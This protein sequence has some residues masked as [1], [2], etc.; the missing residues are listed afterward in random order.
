MHHWCSQASLGQT[1]TSP[2]FTDKVLGQAIFEVLNEYWFITSGKPVANV[3][4]QRIWGQLAYM[5]INI[6]WAFQEVFSQYNSV[7]CWAIHY[8]VTFI[9]SKSHKALV[10]IHSNLWLCLKHH[11]RDICVVLSGSAVTRGVVSLP[12]YP[13]NTAVG[14][15]DIFCS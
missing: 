12:M 1:H 8:P 11:F 2:N 15:A 7:L 6:A 13:Q 14:E 3:G 4:L 10:T 5:T 9:T